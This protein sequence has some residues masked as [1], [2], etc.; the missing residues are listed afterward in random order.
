VNHRFLVLLALLSTLVV[1]RP[2]AADP[3]DS[4][5]E[6]I[7][8]GTPIEA[9]DLRATVAVL[10]ADDGEALD[11]MSW[12][13][14]WTHVRSLCSGV[15]IS[16]DVAVTAGHC[17][18]GTL[19]V[20]AG[21]RTLDDVWTAEVRAVREQVVHPVHDIALLL[22]E[23]P[24][25]S[26][27]P[28]P[29][30]P[31]DEG[32]VGEAGIAEGYGLRVSPEDED[33]LD[34]GQY[35]FLL[36]EAITPIEQ[37]TDDWI[38]TAQ[39]PNQSGVCYGDSGGPLYVERGDELFVAGIASALRQV[40]GGPECGAGAVY[41]SAPG[42]ASWIYEN[43]PGA[44]D[45]QHGGVGGCSAS[46]R[47]QS[48]G[49]LWLAV[50]VPL[51]VVVRARRTPVIVGALLGLCAASIGCGSDGGEASLCNETYDPSG[52]FCDP[53]VERIGLQEAEQQ[54]RSVM[55]SDAWLWSAVGGTEGAVSPDGEADAWFLQYYI[56]DQ[57]AP[58]DAL[59]RSVTVHT[60]GDLQPFQ[61][62][63]T[64]QCIPTE[65]MVPFDSKHI[66]HDAIRHF[67]QAGMPVRLGDEGLLRVFQSHRCAREPDEWSGVGFADS[68]VYY[69]DDGFYLGTEKVP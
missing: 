54:A 24:V 59:L 3:V 38:A 64:L 69:D 46:P 13:T 45:V 32:L 34:Q 20:V 40:E 61:E 39:G 60:S 27:T 53:R 17:V 56:P 10:V 33:L 2:A 50:I 8:N 21:L 7:V 25:A 36:N 42:H 14:L 19:Y 29:I 5:R 11:E 22:L 18:S 31:D 26:A 43:A 63:G 49:G 23:T 47:A 55:P 16:P 9:G 57:L 66:V 35:E 65:P 4:Q 67:E 62:I 48:S 52:N 12:Q 58:P 41:V 44:I 30:L 68:F 28:V 1:E 51:F 6:Y 37:V 15:L